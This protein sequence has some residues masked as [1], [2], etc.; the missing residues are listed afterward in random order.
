MNKPML[1]GVKAESV[2]AV[3]KLPEGYKFSLGTVAHADMARLLSNAFELDVQA[4]APPHDIIALP[5]ITFKGRVVA[6]CS[7]LPPVFLHQFA[8][9]PEH[10]MQ[11]LGRALYEFTVHM[12]NLNYVLVSVDETTT[13]SGH[14]FWKALGFKEIGS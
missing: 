1:L 12:F 9:D 7:V 4:W 8:V 13:E 14:K 2:P 10:Q 6:A 3:P 5:L 11:G